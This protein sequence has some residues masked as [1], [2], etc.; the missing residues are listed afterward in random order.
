[1]CAPKSIGSF[2]SQLDPERTLHRLLG[3]EV[4]TFRRRRDDPSVVGLG[5]PRGLRTTIPGDPRHGFELRHGREYVLAGQIGFE[6][7]AKAQRLMSVKQLNVFDA[8]VEAGPR[9]GI[10]EQGP[11]RFR[12]GC[13]L[14]LVREM[15]RAAAGS[16]LRRPFDRFPLNLLGH[17][18]L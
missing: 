18:I 3:P 10:H 8:G 15:Y 7:R 17:I 5:I 2:L 9:F 6:P 13:N 12:R 16:H 4:A 1:M 14:K 11:D